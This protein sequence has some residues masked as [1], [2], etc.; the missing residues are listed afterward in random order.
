ML[1]AVAATALFCCPG[2]GGRDACISAII[3]QPFSCIFVQLYK[4][5][6]FA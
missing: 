1:R 3:F 2:Y 6:T 4:K 5:K